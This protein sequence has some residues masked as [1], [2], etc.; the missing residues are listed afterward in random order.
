MSKPNAPGFGFLH[1]LGDSGPPNTEHVLAQRPLQRVLAF[2]G[3]SIDDVVNSQIVKNEISGYWKLYRQ[4]QR[5]SEIVDLERQWNPLG[6]I[7]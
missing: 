3:R 2:R 6:K 7:A 4:I 5:H 1:A